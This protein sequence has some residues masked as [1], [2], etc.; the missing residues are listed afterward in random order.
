MFI[1]RPVGAEDH[2]ARHLLL[3]A[4]LMA[5]Y[6]AGYASSAVHTDTADEIWHAYGIARGTRFPLQGPPLGGVLHLGP[7]WFY[8]TAIPLAVG[9]SWLGTA[10][11]IGAF[12]ALK[13]PL[14]Y[15]CGRRLVDAEFGC[16]WASMLLLAGWPSFESLIFLNPNG[17]GTASLAIVALCLRPVTP[18]WGFTVGLVYS[19]AIHVHPTLVPFGLVIAIALWRN[20]HRSANPGWQWALMLAGFA[21]PLLPYVVTQALDGFPDTGSAGGYVAGQ[22]KLANIVNAPSVLAHY[23]FTGPQVAAEYVIGLDDFGAKV[24]A[25]A[26]ALILLPGVLAFRLDVRL[27]N[28]WLAV[29]AA[30]IV[31]AMWAAIMRPTTPIQ[32]TWCLGPPL[33]ALA[34]VSASSL[35]HVLGRWA[36]HG[37]AA[38]AIVSAI[39]FDLGLKAT[40]DSG[41]GRLPSRVMDVKGGLPHRVIEDVWFPA[42]AQRAL[43]EFLCAQSAGANLHGHLAY[44]VDKSLGLP[45][46]LECDRRAALF[47]GGT[48]AG[49]QWLGMSRRFW[50]AAGRNPGCWIG[51]IGVAGEVRVASAGNGL[52]TATGERYLPRVPSGGAIEQRAYEFEAPED[53]LVLVTNVLGGYEEFAFERASVDGNPVTPRISNELSWLLAAPK[54]SSR[55][56]AWKLSIRTSNAAAADVV[57]FDAPSGSGSGIPACR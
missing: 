43:G 57:V 6:V 52:P 32:F 46:M 33:A 28:A 35:Q 8:L 12:C 20:R 1:F 14:A 48:G 19:L 9:F 21:L 56:V 11:F 36:G 23:I 3:L 38:L 34:A 42:T 31:L 30:A 17:V 25:A 5:I 41:E 10:L 27:R 45:P 26:A 39:A 54:V 15:Y 49:A 4:A 18:A 50:E 22:V 55:T 13:F 2:R 40:V 16:L 51:P 24:A 53:S 7:F 44:V 47:I 37:L 29:L